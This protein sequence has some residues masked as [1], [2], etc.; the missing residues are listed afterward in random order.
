M[1]WDRDESKGVDICGVPQPKGGAGPPRV[2]G[3]YLEKATIHFPLQG[4]ERITEVWTRAAYMP[5]TSTIFQT[6][7][8][9]LVV[10]LTI[11]PFA[12]FFPLLL[13]PEQ[14][15]FFHTN[16]K[17]GGTRSLRTWAAP[18][19]LARTYARTPST[20]TKYTRSTGRPSPQSHKV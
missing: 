17:P 8:K 13:L 18:T 5:I 10:S 20:R 6:Y 19:S 15:P 7:H 3:S 2:E 14:N 4:E 11:P 12:N 16:A 1:Y 9:C